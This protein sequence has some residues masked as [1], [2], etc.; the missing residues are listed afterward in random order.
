MVVDLENGVG[1]VDLSV[2]QYIGL[3]NGVRF[4]TG[5]GAVDLSAG[6]C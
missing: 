2:G 4:E 3:F 1:A 5:V 6:D